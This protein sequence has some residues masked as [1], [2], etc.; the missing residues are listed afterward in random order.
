MGF[1][2]KKRK[3]FVAP[4]RD[5][6]FMSLGPIFLRVPSLSLSDSKGK[7]DEV[8]FVPSSTPI[9]CRS[10]S[11]RQA[12]PPPESQDDGNKRERQRSTR[13]VRDRSTHKQAADES[14]TT[15]ALTPPCS[16]PMVFARVPEGIPIQSI[17]PNIASTHRS[18]H[19]A[20][21]LRITPETT[22]V[23]TEHLKCPA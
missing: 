23:S 15:A 6:N 22:Q 14:S 16:S 9:P 10:T 13:D 3:T 8:G 17:S 20:C 4:I 18:R 21:M 19:P 7:L 12:S 11:S 1:T 2:A 5:P